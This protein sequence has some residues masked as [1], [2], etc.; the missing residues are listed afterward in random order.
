M[1][2]FF[3]QPTQENRSTECFKMA[4]RGLRGLIQIPARNPGQIG[5]QN[6]NGEEQR[7]SRV[8][9]PRSS[10]REASGAKMGRDRARLGPHC[11]IQDFARCLSASFHCRR[12]DLNL[13]LCSGCE[14]I[15]ACLITLRIKTLG[16]VPSRFGPACRIRPQGGGGLSGGMR[17][18]K[19]EEENPDTAQVPVRVCARLLART[20]RFELTVVKAKVSLRGIRGL[21][22][23]GLW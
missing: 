6:V 16:L 12:F 3:I 11:F 13:G 23:R 8:R 10:K 14:K 20:K 9:L 17:G 15:A 22:W 7:P 2:V 4:A 19:G 1:A 5:A 21:A 18:P